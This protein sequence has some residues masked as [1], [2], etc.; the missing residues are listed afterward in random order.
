MS[1]TIAMS[2][3]I[4]SKEETR[5]LVVSL[6]GEL[7]LGQDCTRLAQFIQ[8]HADQQGQHLVFDLSGI[9]QIDSTGIGLFIDAYSR[10]EKAGGQ[11][12]LAGAGGAVRDAFHVTRLDTVFRFVPTADAA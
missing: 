3:S 2:L 8:T 11:M 7:M 10:L 4:E 5:K 1:S 9:S 12:T 6:K